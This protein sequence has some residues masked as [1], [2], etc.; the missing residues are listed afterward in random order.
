[1]LKKTLVFAA[2][3]LVLVSVIFLFI[4]WKEEDSRFVSYRI[5]PK[6]Q[7][8]KL[9]WKDDD[10]NILHNAK[11]LNNWLAKKGEELIF[12]MNGGMFK[13]DYSPVGLFIE[14][15]KQI[16]PLDTTKGTGNFYMQPNGVFYLTKTGKAAICKTQDFKNRPEIKFATQSGPMLLVNEQINPLFGKA[17]TNLNI[18]NGVGILPDGELLFTICREKVNFYDLA[19]FFKSQG[20]I[21]ALYL[22]GFVSKMYLPQK[23]IEQTDGELGLLIGVSGK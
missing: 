6:K 14:N 7:T 2:A 19:D 22:D 9:Y 21:N 5:D 3:L 16:T 17:S 4:R 12:A 18:R 20:C 11:N 8:V 1:M 15:G 10:G 23:N 13:S